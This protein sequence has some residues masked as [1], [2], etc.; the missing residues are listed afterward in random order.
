MLANS[1]TRAALVATLAVCTAA[2]PALAAEK[3]A[4]D[5]KAA[6]GSPS[7]IPSP[8]RPV[9]WRGDGTGRFPA[10]DPPTEWGRTIKGFYTEL[11]CQGGKPK[12]P[13]AAGE[14]LNMGFVRDW[15]IIGPFDTKDFKS[16]VDENIL[17]G[18]TM[19]QP[20]VGEK[21]GGKAWTHWHISVDNQSRSDGKL[22]LD[23]AQAYD[24][25]QQQEWQN[26]PGSME[27]WAAYAQTGLWSPVAGKVR[28]RIEGNGTRKA[29]L[30]GQA[31]KMPGQWDPSPPVDLKKGWNNLVVKAVS[32]KGGWNF[33][34]HVAPMPPYEYQTENIRWMTRMPGTSWCSPII[35]GN[36]IFVSADG[37][38]LVCLNK[39]DGKVLW[40]RST[41]YYHA[42][43]ADE[44]AKFADLLPKVKQLSAAC[45]A[46]PAL[47]NATISPDGMK[48]DRNAALDKSIKDKCELEGAIQQA[49]AKADRRKYD[50]WGNDRDTSKYN[51]TSDGT[52]VWAAFWGGNKGIGANAVACFDLDGKR[53]WSAFCGQTNISE[54]GTHCSPAL[55]G[56][57][58]VFK[59]GA[60]LFGFEKDTGKMVWRKE[61]GGGLGASTLPVRIGKEVLAYVPQAGIFRPSDGTQLWKAPFT[62]GV[63]TP[64]VVDGVIYG[65]DEVRFFACRLPPQ[66][67]GSV[68]T[69][70]NIPWKNIAFH[71]P[72]IFTDS[73]I[74]SPLYD[75]GLVYVASEGGALN[76]VDAKT[77][78]RVYAQAM[79]NLNPRL[80]WVFTVGICSSTSLGG[81]Y[82]FV[83]DDQGQ[84]LVLEPGPRYKQVAK[85]LLVEYDNN[86][87]QPEAQSNF[88]FE[89]KRIYFRT[90]GF[91]YCI[92]EK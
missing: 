58:L 84:T 11:Q 65:I 6:L 24:K 62:T 21:S 79:D 76:V 27:P 26:H 57:Y 61:I 77:G 71:M 38:T 73:I 50:A 3:T 66:A 44:R 31:V 4:G 87:V 1:L 88:Y 42:V 9:G 51:P 8:E 39:S 72:G 52:Y 40:M 59:S 34:A 45:L 80:Q 29:W 54:H 47:I 41:T 43:D 22:F 90:S 56:D 36:K 64:T 20:R 75:K 13:A 32:S 12:S 69:L 55:C 74:G 15:L 85:N 63:P 49:M 2:G 82:V 16:G 14:P 30:N 92:G 18:E 78:R 25:T 5:A 28:L 68:A 60:V 70:L 17:S 67:A 37:G 48:A 83:R 53:I 91:L 46:L 10:A 86:G 35:V 33:V 23:F 89:G 81:K 19:L 7:F